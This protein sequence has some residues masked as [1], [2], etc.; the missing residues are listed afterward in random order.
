MGYEIVYCASCQ[1]QVRGGEFE[2]RIAIRVEDLAYCVK[3]AP[4]VLKSLPP[5]RVDEILGRVATPPPIRKGST[6]RIA[7]IQS[8]TSGRLK[9]QTAAAA[10]APPAPP[11]QRNGLLIAS[12]AGAVVLVGVAIVVLS[13]GEPAPETPEKPG[14][15]RLPQPQAQIA[16]P[17]SVENLASVQALVDLE[18][19]AASPADP[20]E[21]LI[22]C[23]EIKSLVRGTPQEAKWKAIQGQATAAKKVKDADQSITLGLEQVR[24]LRKYDVRYARQAEIEQL[25]ARVKAMGGPRQAEVQ[26]AIDDYAKDVAEAK[27]RFKDLVAWYRFSIAERLG[28]DDSGCGNNSISVEGV[29]WNGSFPDGGGGVRFGGSG[30]IGIPVP[31]RGDFSIAFWIRTRQEAV[32]DKQWFEGPGLVDAEVPGVVDDFGTALLRGK[33]AFGVGNPDVTL[34][35]KTQINDGR[36]RH[37]AATRDSRTGEMKIY[38]DGQAEGTM[39]G[40]KGPRSAPNRMTIGGLQTGT[41]MLVG[42]IDDVRLYARVLPD[43]EVASLARR[44]NGR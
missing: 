8:K 7:K 21:I 5:A 30:V 15:P 17:N 10:P 6:S 20:L 42:E 24:S 11:P 37:L 38:V 43:T 22:R 33:F 28:A 41:L 12:A 4:D 23:D 9:A 13:S 40:P 19:L 16:K 35:S 31:V 39:S 3:C 32:G 18:Q 26:A 25:L 27:L 14:G 36:W 1:T 34:L 2:K 29:S 44:S